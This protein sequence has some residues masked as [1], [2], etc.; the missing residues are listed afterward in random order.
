MLGYEV[1]KYTKLT[2]KDGWHTP[3]GEIGAYLGGYNKGLEVI[4]DIIKEIEFIKDKTL[5]N[6][7]AEKYEQKG[8]SEAL[9]IINN[10]LKGARE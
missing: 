10:H 8:L 2:G 5:P 1:A 3:I 7:L 6:C 4:D 9:D